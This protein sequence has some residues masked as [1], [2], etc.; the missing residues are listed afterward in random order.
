MSSADLVDRAAKAAGYD[1]KLGGW[2]GISLPVEIV[3]T[4]LERIEYLEKLNPDEVQL[5]A[6]R[7][8]N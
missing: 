2:K 7:K 1:W 3:E 8:D 4:L 5:V 6:L